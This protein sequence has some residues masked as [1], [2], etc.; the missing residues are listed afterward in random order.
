MKVISLI[1]NKSIISDN[2]E[3]EPITTRLFECEQITGECSDQDY[4][5][6]LIIIIINTFQLISIKMISEIKKNLKKI[7]LKI[8]IFSPLIYLFWFRYN[9]IPNNA[10]TYI[11]KINDFTSNFPSR[12]H[13]L[14][15]LYLDCLDIFTDLMKIIY[16]ILL[17][18]C[19]ICIIS[20]YL[21][22]FLGFLISM[23]FILDSLLFEKS[24]IEFLLCLT[25]QFNLNN[26]Y[27]SISENLLLTFGLSFRISYTLLKCNHIN[28]HLN[29]K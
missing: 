8:I 23:V 6:T 5:Y 13:L 18:L 25:K 4:K 2:F 1:L 28:T 22:V 27:E 24:G 11:T 3:L 12:K 19:F 29:E 16:L 7:F 9:D 21:Y 15:D 14:S 20:K 17:G 10:N 26:L